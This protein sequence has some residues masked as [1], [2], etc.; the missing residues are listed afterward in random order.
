LLYRARWL[1]GLYVIR[2]TTKPVPGPRWPSVGTHFGA[3]FVA[4]RA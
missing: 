4:T 3:I 1:A 2:S